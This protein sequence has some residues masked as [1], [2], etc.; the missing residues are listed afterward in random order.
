[1][2]PMALDIAT[3]QGE[4]TS[5][6]IAH[7]LARSSGHRAYYCRTH[8]FFRGKPIPGSWAFTTMLCFLASN[9]LLTGCMSWELPL[10]LQITHAEQGA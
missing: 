8:M 1:M 9:P 6:L 2:P 7:Y 5:K 4:V 3:E 10:G